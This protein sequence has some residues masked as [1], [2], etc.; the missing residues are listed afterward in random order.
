MKLVRIH[1]DFNRSAIQFY[2]EKAIDFF[3]EIMKQW[4]Q[5]QEYEPLVYNAKELKKALSLETSKNSEY[6]NEF[7]LQFAKDTTT[8]FK[9]RE[10]VI[11]GNAF[12]FVE[13]GEKN[14]FTVELNEKLIQYVFTKSDIEIMKK[15]KKKEK[16]TINEIEQY[17]QNK[18]KYQQLMLY[19]QTDLLNLSG[20]YSKRL[21]M[22]LIQF[23]NTG[24]FF[25]KYDEFKK[26]MEIPESYNQGHIDI[27]IFKK[28]KEDLQEKAGI[29]ITEI[30][31]IKKGRSIDRI[32]ITFTASKDRFKNLKV[33]EEKEANIN[34]PK[35]SVEERNEIGLK[36]IEELR[37]NI[38]RT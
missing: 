27:N 21:Y 13:D 31:K 25:M 7:I 5:M 1:K 35:M 22:L 4:N 26:V 8:Q 11:T 19:S 34:Q 20:K 29:E 24:K 37:K 12:S 10:K 18:N 23:K 3:S 28:S 15:N 17:N 30:K 32:E 14:T 16:M 33:L 38:K 9:V 36:H 6:F 2:K